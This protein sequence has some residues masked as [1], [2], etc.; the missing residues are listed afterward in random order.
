MLLAGR[1]E[2]Q[3]HPA[4]DAVRESGAAWTILECSFFMQ[5]FTE[6]L[7]APKGD[8]VTFPA[9]DVREPFIDCEDIADVAVAALMDDAHIGKTYELT[10]PRSITFAEATETLSRATGRPLRFVPV[11]FEHFAQV[12]AEDL[13]PPVVEFFIDL[14]RFLTDGHNDYVTD[15]VEKVLGRPARD[16]RDFAKATAETV[17]V[18]GP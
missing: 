6:G 5:N 13:P 1:G 12:L 18:R 16:I 3:V 17:R 9:G 8:T 11:T 10:G 14:V 2:P 7:L 4:E 15:T